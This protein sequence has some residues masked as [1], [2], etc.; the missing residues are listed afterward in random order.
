MIYLTK[1]LSETIKNAR[2]KNKL[3]Q[4]E[5]ASYL[6]IS[7]SSYNR[8]E[9]NVVK[10]ID[11]EILS[12][13]SELL[14]FDYD[15]NHNL[16]TNKKNVSVRLPIDLYEKLKFFQFE[17]KF[18]SMSDVII[19]CLSEYTNNVELA[20]IKY[21]L[22]DFF[23]ELILKTFAKE[24]KELNTD[25]NKYIHLLE[26]LEEKYSFDKDIEQDELDLIDIKRKRAKTY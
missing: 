11:E 14:K 12:K 24:L 17:N 25:K 3:T 23:E 22:Q 18:T 15:A 8:I 4:Q 9:N 19:H 7:F 6:N 10:R 16:F 1:T 5:V 26:F 20:K 13:L 2:L 21:D